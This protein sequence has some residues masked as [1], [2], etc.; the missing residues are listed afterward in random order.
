ME[1][2]A[3]E[4]SA[5]TEAKGRATLGAIAHRLSAIK[6][7]QLRLSLLAE[8][9]GDLTVVAIKREVETGAGFLWGTVAFGGGCA[10]YFQLPREPWPAAFPL[11]CLALFAGFCKSGRAQFPRACLAGAA[12]VAAG[13]SIAQIQTL[14]TDTP[15]LRRAVTVDIRGLVTKVEQRPRGRV[16]YTLRV[17][18]ISGSRT[19]RSGMEGLELVRVSARSGA[20]PITVGQGIEGRARLS[21]TP[22]PAFPGAYDFSFFTWFDGIGASGFF[23]GSPRRGESSPATAAIDIGISINQLRQHIAFLIH[24]ALPDQSGALA[25]ALIVGDRSGID[26]TTVEALRQAGLAHILAISGLHMALVVLTVMFIT[27]G[28][29]AAMPAVALNVPGKKWAGVAGLF[30]ASGYLLVSGASI[31]TQ[32]AYIMV[33]V[34]LVAVLLDR[35]ALTMR[36]V[37][38]AAVIILLLSPHAVLMPGFQMSFA[39]V[40]ALVACYDVVSRR[41]DARPRKRHY[42]GV[43]GGIIRFVRRDLLGLALTSLVAGLATALFAAYHFYRIAP[44]GLLA[45]VLAM[46]LVTFAVMPLALLST[47]LMPFGLE[48]GVLTMMAIPLQS[49]VSTAEIVTGMQPSGGTGALSGPVL[50]FGTMALVFLTVMRTGLKLLA[51]PFIIM[52]AISAKLLDRPDMIIAE[53]A[54]QVGLFTQSNQ[55]ILLRPNADRFTTGIWKMAYAAK[56]AKNTVPDTSQS[57]QNGRGQGFTCDLHGCSAVL[58]GMTIVVVKSTAHLFEDCRMADILI[59]PYAVNQPCAA[60]R[61]GRKLPIIIDSRTLTSTGSQAIWIDEKHE[62]GGDPAKSI[63]AIPSYGRHRRP[64]TRHRSWK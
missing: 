57:E 43:R 24:D 50:L 33:V 19:R 37:A 36:N 47:L 39:A 31:S 26:E 16:R 54:R 18:E 40:A 56:P 64:W 60:L 29:I 1:P 2:D 9:L 41:K 22:G 44:F 32:R 35:R 52:A 59:I 20:V 63:R 8:R 7:L 3:E 46:P 49:V 38:M 28:V 45:N 34:M 30:S 12:L 27:R 51:V 17:I 14:L 55:M 13:L 23:L 10:A 6:F 15:S 11:L 58:K 62:S 53:G 21:P 4:I 5:Q 61:S 42:G 25:T 48:G